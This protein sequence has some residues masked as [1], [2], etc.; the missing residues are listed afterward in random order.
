VQR[1]YLAIAWGELEPVVQR[2]DAPIGRDPAQ[3][4]RMAV[5]AGGKPA[6]TDVERVAV[7]NGF[8]ACA[9]G[10]TPGARTRSACTWPTAGTRWWPMPVRR[11]PALGLQRQAL[12][13][14]RLAFDHPVDPRTG[15]HRLRAAARLRRRLGRRDRGLR[16]GLQGLARRQL[17]CGLPR[18]LVPAHPGPAARR[19]EDR[20]SAQRRPPGNASS[21][22]GPANPTTPPPRRWPRQPGGCRTPMSR[23]TARAV[24]DCPTQP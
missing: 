24:A 23:P 3:R 1:Q 18:P 8:S 15:L 12:H 6:Q 4:T 22:A 20:P 13:A 17:Q 16:S 5:V 2:I 21:A 9:A 7:R 10:C 19:D 14:T 11:R